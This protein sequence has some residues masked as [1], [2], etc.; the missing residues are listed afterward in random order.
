MTQLKKATLFNAL[1]RETEL[2]RKLQ[3]HDRNATFINLLKE[4]PHSNLLDAL[5]GFFNVDNCEVNSS[6]TEQK[7]ILLDSVIQSLKYVQYMLLLR[8]RFP[9]ENYVQQI[10]DGV[11]EIDALQELGLQIHLL[12]LDMQSRVI[13]KKLDESSRNIITTLENANIP[14][15]SSWLGQHVQNVNA[16]CGTIVCSSKVNSKTNKLRLNKTSMR[17][18]MEYTIETTEES[19]TLYSVGIDIID[20]DLYAK[21]FQQLLN[22]LYD[23]VTNDYISTFLYEYDCCRTSIMEIEWEDGGFTISDSDSLVDYLDKYVYSEVL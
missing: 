13:L 17:A 16:I 3:N 12:N 1:I 22:T 9:L 6:N 21:A 8:L 15:F 19:R 14:Y 4:T 18:I 11:L 23:D 20:F 7:A 10:N 2:W 5:Y